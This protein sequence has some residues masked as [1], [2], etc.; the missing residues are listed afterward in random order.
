MLLLQIECIRLSLYSCCSCY[1]KIEAKVIDTKFSTGD[2]TGLKNARML[3]F[4]CSEVRT[5]KQMYVL[6][7]ASRI[8]NRRLDYVEQSNTPTYA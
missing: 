5:R 4:V 2:L 8:R 1:R 3:E 6:T 7:H